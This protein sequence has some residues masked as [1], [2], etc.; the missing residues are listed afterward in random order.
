[1][2]HYFTLIYYIWIEANS[3]ILFCVVWT[4]IILIIVEI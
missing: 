4:M 1:M 2:P 3:S